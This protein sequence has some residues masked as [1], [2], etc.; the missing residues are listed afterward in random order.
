MHGEATAQEGGSGRGMFADGSDTAGAKPDDFTGFNVI[1]YGQGPG[2]AQTSVS[3]VDLS[4]S[5]RGR[6]S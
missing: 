3:I 4:R 2:F 6:E 5:D 1:E